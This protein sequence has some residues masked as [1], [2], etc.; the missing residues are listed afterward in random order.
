M[1]QQNIREYNYRKWYIR[2]SG[3]NL[4]VNLASDERNYN[5]EVVFST[6]LI[7]QNDGN[8]L[9]ISFDLNNSGSSQLF[10]LNYGIYNSANTLV[11]LNYYNPNN[12]NLD[13]FTASTLCDIGLTGIDNGLVDRMSGKTISFTM[14]LLDDVDKFNRYDFDRRFK[15][16]QVTGYTDPPNE[17]FS[18]NTDRTVYEIVSKTNSQIGT[19]N[20]LYGGFYQGFFKLFGYDYD[21]F[22]NRTNKGWSVEMILRPRL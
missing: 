15:M 9:P 10:V 12:E 8:R 21:V 16:F 7:A 14:G 19:Y 20:Q 11:S 3:Q 22:P 2:P 17:R 4:D 6:N 5:E 18:G 1:S 13:M